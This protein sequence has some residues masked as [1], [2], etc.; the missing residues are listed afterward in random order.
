MYYFADG[1][2]TLFM[3]FFGGTFVIFIILFVCNLVGG[4]KQWNKNNQSPRVT[5][6]ATVTAKRVH[7]D[8]QPGTTTYI[9]GDARIPVQSAGTTTTT[10]YATFQ[11]ESGDRMEFLV[12]GPEYGMLEEGDAGKL[13]FQGTRFLGFERTV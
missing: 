6:P 11:F 5:A 10:Y 12:S 3:I 1:S 7:V 9:G 2:D 8:H 13:T 4:A